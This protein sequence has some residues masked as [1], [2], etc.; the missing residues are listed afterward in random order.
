MD[1]DGDGAGATSGAFCESFT[2]IVGDE[3][4]NPFAE[5]LSQ[6]SLSLTVWVAV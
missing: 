2:R 6:P 3:Y 4:V 5:R 1:G